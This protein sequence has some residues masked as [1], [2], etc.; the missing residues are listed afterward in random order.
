MLNKGL[1]GVNRAQQGVL[2]VLNKGCSTR[3]VNSAQQG[4][5][6]IRGYWVLIVH[7]KG[8]L[9]VNSAQQGVIGC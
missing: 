5:L 4:V 2:I 9:G 8:L 1:L 7:N 6:I 3:G